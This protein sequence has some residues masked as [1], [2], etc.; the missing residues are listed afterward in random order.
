MV[1]N[2]SSSIVQAAV[3]VP[4][5]TSFEV[6][7]WCKDIMKSLATGISFSLR[8]D[9]GDTNLLLFAFP[10]RSGELQISSGYY[11][12]YSCSLSQHFQETQRGDFL[13]HDIKLIFIPSA[14]AALAD[15]TGSLHLPCHIY[16]SAG[17]LTQ[18]KERLKKNNF[19]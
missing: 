8:K 13:L 6:F 17:C 4:L 14:T 2:G 10:L 19:H 11:I 16:S 15:L 12:A 18:L 7:K 1:G 9:Y 5:R 3:W